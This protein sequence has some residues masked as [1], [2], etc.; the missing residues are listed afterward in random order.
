MPKKAYVNHQS[1]EKNYRVSGRFVDNYDIHSVHKTVFE[2]FEDQEKIKLPELEKELEKYQTELKETKSITPLKIKTLNKKLSELQN[3]IKE[4]KEQTQLTKYIE[5]SFP[6]LEAYGAVGGCNSVVS[7]GKPVQDKNED[8]GQVQLRIAIIRKYLSIAGKYIRVDVVQELPLNIFCPGCKENLKELAADE[9]GVLKCKCGYE[10]MTITR[11]YTSSEYT[12]S[13]KNS[14][15]DRDNFIKALIRYEGREL[16]KLPEDL[17]QKLD[18]YFVSSGMPSGEEVRSGKVDFAYTKDMMYKAMES[19]R[20]PIYEHAN[21]VMSKYWGYKLP[22]ITHLYDTIILHYDITQKVFQEEL[23]EDGNSSLNTQFRLFKHLQ[24][25]NHPCSWSDF[26][27]PK[28]RS[29]VEKD[30]TLWKSMCLKTGEEGVK[31]GIVFIPT[32]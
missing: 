18:A 28:T 16:D 3:S 11:S 8:E 19:I 1:N 22:D 23:N 24:M 12:P 9:N 31:V 7:F 15:N 25:V 14:Y 32:L 26:R 2:Y 17:Y 21:L 6:Y 20:R 30:E 13:S 10:K 5:E 29:I 27:I 4:I